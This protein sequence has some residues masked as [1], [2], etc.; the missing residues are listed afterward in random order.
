MMSARDYTYHLFSRM[1][2]L[3]ESQLFVNKET[4]LID[5]VVKH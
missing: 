2:F 3:D 5:L 1:T 4:H